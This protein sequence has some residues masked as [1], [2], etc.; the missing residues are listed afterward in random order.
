[1]QLSSISI[2]DPLT[3]DWH[4]KRSLLQLHII[5]LGLFIEPY[6]TC[7]I[8]LGSFRIGDTN[9]S[10]SKEDLEALISIEDQCVSAAR[11]SARVASLLQ[12]DNLVRS[13]CW[14]SL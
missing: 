1:M 8:D 4:T 11:Q 6:R 13:H 2:S 3:L 10:I 9:K 5:F 14:V 7:L 12:F